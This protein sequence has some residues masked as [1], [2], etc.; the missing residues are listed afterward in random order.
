VFGRE[1]QRFVLDNM[2]AVIEINNQKK[3]RDGGDEQ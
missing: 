2:A 3:T 1:A